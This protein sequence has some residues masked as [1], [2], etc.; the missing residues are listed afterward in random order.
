MIIFITDEAITKALHLRGQF[1]ESFALLEVA[2][3]CRNNRYN[4]YRV[5]QGCSTHPS[6][7]QI[8]FLIDR[9]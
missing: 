6:N 9:D 8:T 3:S 1:N 7:L 4:F 2:A 5:A